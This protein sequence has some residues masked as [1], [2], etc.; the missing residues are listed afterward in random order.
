[1]LVL[2]KTGELCYPSSTIAG[3]FPKTPQIIWKGQSMTPLT[4]VEVFLSYALVLREN[5]STI[6][7]TYKNCVTT[8]II[9]RNA[10]SLRDLVYYIPQLS[11][12]M[13]MEQKILMA[14]PD[15]NLIDYR[16]NDAE[17]DAFE[18]WFEKSAPNPT[19]TLIALAEKS[20]KVSLTYVENSSAWCV[21]ITGQKTA[22]FNSESTLTTWAD[23][24]LEGLYM[25]F[26]KA[27]IVFEGGVW[28]TKTTSRRG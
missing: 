3:C 19:E 17:L 10:E 8:M 5:L 12:T 7:F 23:E 25:A 6:P 4:P 18:T 26:Y 16:L 21:S 27:M 24:P 1:M 11:F 28:K 13:C 22:K 2:H 9:L 20:Y 14:K 15:F